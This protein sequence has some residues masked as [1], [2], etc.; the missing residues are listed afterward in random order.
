MLWPF[1][2]DLGKTPERVTAADVLG[3]AHGIGRSGRPPSPVTVGARIAYVSSC[4][5]FLIRM[6][7]L[8]FNPCDPVERPRSIPSP[9]R[10]WSADEVRRLLAV[11]PD[12]VPGRRDRAI[13]LT[14]VLTGRRRAEALGLRAGDITVEDGTPFYAYRGKGGKRGRR[15]LP[16]P[17]HEAM[18]ATLGDAGLDLGTMGGP[19]QVAVAG[20]GWRAGHQQ[21]HVLRPVPA[22][23]RGDRSATDGAPRPAPYRGEAPTRRRGVHRGGVSVPRPFVVVGRVVVPCDEA[24]LRHRLRGMAEGRSRREGARR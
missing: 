19:D 23:P 10:G 12:T 3:F 24:R 13:L 2:S 6:G 22:L 18:R 11:V 16:R 8:S 14:L 17:A 5:R 20:Q 15:E 1:F 9:A 21:R 7:Q 4:Y